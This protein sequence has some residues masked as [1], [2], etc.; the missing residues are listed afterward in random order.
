M[1]KGI[2][3][4]FQTSMS[5]VWNLT[6][7][8]PTDSPKVVSKWLQNK[9]LFVQLHGLLSQNSYHAFNGFA[10]WLSPFVGLT[11][12]KYLD[13][14]FNCR[15]QELW[16][17]VKTIL[18]CCAIM[19]GPIAYSE[20]V[21]GTILVGSPT[22]GS[23]TSRSLRHIINGQGRWTYHNHFFWVDDE[24]LQSLCTW[25]EKKTKNPR[26]VWYSI[27]SKFV[28]TISR[29]KFGLIGGRRRRRKLVL[30]NLKKSQKYFKTCDYSL[31]V[32]K[33]SSHM[34]V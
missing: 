7:E 4:H 16:V 3:Y 31:S 1:W 12:V 18:R 29:F 2:V 8:T 19:L 13:S 28:Y 10:S 17:V 22:E 23:S 15:Q 34:A 9:A 25:L 6:C 5:H 30:S 24:L 26:V 11:F 27:I 14:F 32:H 33:Y 21:Y 20:L